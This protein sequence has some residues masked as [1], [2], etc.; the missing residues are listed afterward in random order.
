MKR[1]WPNERRESGEDISKFEEL[2]RRDGEILTGGENDD[3]RSS[4]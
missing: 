3:R 4:T 1:S 2:L